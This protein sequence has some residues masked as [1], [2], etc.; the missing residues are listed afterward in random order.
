MNHTQVS[1][2]LLTFL[3]IPSL[4]PPFLLFSFIFLSYI[5]FFSFL[6]FYFLY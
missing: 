4:S 3:F 2:S 6:F 1:K 5:A